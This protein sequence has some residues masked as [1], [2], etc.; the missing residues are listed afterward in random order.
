MF[1]K[2]HIVIFCA[3]MKRSL[4]S[5]T[6]QKRFFE[7]FTT[8]GYFLPD[9]YNGFHADMAIHPTPTFHLLLPIV[10]ALVHH[11]AEVQLAK[12]RQQISLFLPEK[13]DHT[14]LREFGVRS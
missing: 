4:T 6:F 9:P 10:G 12:G 1:A 5:A 7:Y 13:T 8:N 14:V 3:K 11:G 2:S